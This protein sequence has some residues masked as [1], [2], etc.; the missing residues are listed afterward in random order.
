MTNAARIAAS[1]L[2]VLGLVLGFT[3]APAVY[4]AECLPGDMQT[5]MLRS[6]I[7]NGPNC[8]RYWTRLCGGVM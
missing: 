2:T 7:P 5:S 1:I 4:A 8:T 3:S 6:D